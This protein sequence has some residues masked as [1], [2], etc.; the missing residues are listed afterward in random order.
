MFFD[1]ETE[2]NEKIQIKFALSPVSQKNALANMQAEIP[3]WNFEKVKQQTQEQWN[4]ELNKIQIGA[5]PSH[6]LNF[7]TGLYHAFI[8]PT[9]TKD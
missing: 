2:E 9:N 1:F 3:H 7:Y 8:S 4:A 6:M 5:S